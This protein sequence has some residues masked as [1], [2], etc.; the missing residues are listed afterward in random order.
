MNLG[1]CLL[2]IFGIFC[3]LFPKGLQAYLRRQNSVLRFSDKYFGVGLVFI[4]ILGLLF[5]FI[6]VAVLLGFF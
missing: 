6:F 1:V 3:F 2:L 4:R 5:I